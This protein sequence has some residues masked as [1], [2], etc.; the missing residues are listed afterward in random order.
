MTDLHQLLDAKH[1]SAPIQAVVLGAA[2]RVSCQ[3][4]DRSRDGRTVPCVKEQGT[5]VAL[6]PA[7]RSIAIAMEP[8]QAE[9][10]GER[11]GARLERKARPTTYVHLS[12][13]QLQEPDIAARAIELAV[14][15]LEL[16]GTRPVGVRDG[17][18]DTGPK[19]WGTCPVHGYVLNAKAECPTC[20]E[21]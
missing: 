13:Q 5:Q 15:S 4:L 2:E 17:D 18:E 9:I 12:A 8:A 11:L 6:Y 19:E 14:A 16:C 1:V 21:D 20:D 10:W 7:R 3:P